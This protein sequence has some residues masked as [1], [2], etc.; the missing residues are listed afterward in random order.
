[1][2]GREIRKKEGNEGGREKEGGME[3]GMGGGSE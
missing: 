3:R 2:G 1:M